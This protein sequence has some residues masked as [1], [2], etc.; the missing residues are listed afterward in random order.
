MF[1]PKR[2]LVWQVGWQLRGLESLQSSLEKAMRP[3]IA[4]AVCGVPNTHNNLPH[5]LRATSCVWEPEKTSNMRQNAQRMS[6]VA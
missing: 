4:T 3:R 5:G 1:K 2:A 6:V